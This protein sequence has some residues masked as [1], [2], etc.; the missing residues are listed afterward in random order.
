M[1]LRTL[2][3]GRINSPV[4]EAHFSIACIAWKSTEFGMRIGSYADFR[5]PPMFAEF[6]P[7][8]FLATRQP[9]RIPHAIRKHR[10]FLLTRSAREVLGPNEAFIKENFVQ[11]RS[12]QSLFDRVPIRYRSFAMYGEQ[13]R[14]HYA[15]S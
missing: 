14:V 9:A 11:L 1:I 12:V 15:V 3:E 5:R 6:F 4:Q 8:T 13:L 7:Q 2:F 10:P